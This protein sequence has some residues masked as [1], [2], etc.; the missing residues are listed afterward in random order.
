MDTVWLVL[1][2]IL[3]FVICSSGLG[4]L[5]IG[6]PGTWLIVAASAVFALATDGAA[7]PWLAVILY[8]LLSA[9]AEVFEA[10]V[11]AWGAK[12]FGGSKWAMIGAIAGGILGAI[13]FTAIVPVIG[14]LIGAFGGAFLGAFGLEYAVNRDFRQA[15]SSGTGA[16]LGRIAAVVV[17]AGLAVAM[18]ISSFVLLIT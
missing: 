14:T 3:Y 10:L 11:G 5:I 16:F 6:L 17:K 4:M 7:I 13:L 2:A 8:A 12:K 15:R 1:G 9:A 18:I